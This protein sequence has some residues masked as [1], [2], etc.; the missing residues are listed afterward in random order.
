MP[1]IASQLTLFQLGPDLGALLQ[2]SLQLMQHTRAK[3]TEKAYR[4]DWRNF[5]EWCQ[6]AGRD[7]LPA[8]PETIAMYVTALMAAGKSTKTAH[9]HLAAIRAKHVDGKI[10]KPDTTTARL[11]LNGTRR[12]RKEQPKQKAALTPANLLRMAKKTDATTPDGARDRAV[13]ILG[14]ATSLRRSE[15]SALNLDDV[16]HH[17]KGLII[18]N[19]HGKT[20]QLGVGRIIPVFR[21]RHENTCPVLAI[22]A[23]VKQRGQDPGPLFVRMTPANTVTQKRLKPESIARIVQTL[24]AKIGLDA[25]RYGAHS[26]R[27]GCITTAAEGHRSDSEIMALSGHKSSTVMRS[28]IRRAHIFPPRDPLGGVL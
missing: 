16:T 9:K 25:K 28:Y 18:N 12:L 10:P 5:C 4:S 20:D 14:F 23:W 17:P 24:A 19:R 11:I 15:L 21:G 22:R 6:Q 8:D 2:E 27:A 1:G 3:S 13:L 26:M 7:T